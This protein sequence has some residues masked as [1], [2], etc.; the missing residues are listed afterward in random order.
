MECL[1]CNS[2]FVGRSDKKFCSDNCR[3]NY[4]NKMN[5]EITNERNKQWYVNNKEKALNN[6]ELKM[7]NG[8]KYRA[9]KY[10]IP[11]DLDLSDIVIPDTC[12]LLGIPLYRTEGKVKNNTPSLDKIEPSK[13]YVKNNVWVISWKA[14][15]KKSNLSTEEIKAF[16]TNLLNKIK[17]C[18]A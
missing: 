2:E 18:D 7:Y 13:G 17:E 1:R 15:R 10:N 4:N 16:C 3:N 14:N 11:F 6:I 8:V 9:K 12:P 5:K